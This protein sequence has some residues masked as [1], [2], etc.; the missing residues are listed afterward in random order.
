MKTNYFLP[1]NSANISQ[2][3]SRG[4]IIPSINIDGWISDIQSKFG[5]SILLCNKPLTS[6]TDCSLSIVF[7]DEEITNRNAISEN[8]FVF[9]KPLT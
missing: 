4:I 8:F 7:S 5:N 1:L 2:Y 3:F 9:N 6:E